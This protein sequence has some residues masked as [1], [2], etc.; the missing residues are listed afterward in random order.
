MTFKANG[1]P[2][3][4]DKSDVVIF[5]DGSWQKESDKGVSAFTVYNKEGQHIFE[6]FQIVP[7]YGNHVTE[8]RAIGMA[9]RYAKKNRF[10]ARIYTDFLSFVRGFRRERNLD[11]SSELLYML[12][13]MEN[14]VG[15]YNFISIKYV[16]RDTEWGQM[17]AH[18]LARQTMLGKPIYPL[19]N[20]LK[21]AA[22]LRSTHKKGREM[23]RER[24]RNA[25]L[26][27]ESSE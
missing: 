1:S 10:T 12:K 14:L 3:V 5:T 13:T 9:I 20:W 8:Y 23:E 16:K 22:W 2:V 4:Y 6:E 15:D 19:D 21:H 24:R 26:G 7:A 18:H 17:R 11:D 27:Y 25:A